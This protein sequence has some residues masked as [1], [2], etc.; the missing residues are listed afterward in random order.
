MSD[1]RTDPIRRSVAIDGS[2]A[3]AHRRKRASQLAHPI[4]A[5]RDGADWSTNRSCGPSLTRAVPTAV[6]LKRVAE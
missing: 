5:L 1:F 4:P 6:D 2:G 3:C